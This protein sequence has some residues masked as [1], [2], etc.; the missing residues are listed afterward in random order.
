MHHASGIGVAKFNPP[1][2][3]K[4]LGHGRSLK[5]M[6][7]R[8]CGLVARVRHE[9]HKS[10][11][12]NSLRYSMLADCPATTFSAA[13]NAAMSVG[14]FR[15][16]LQILVVDVKRMWPV[17][18]DED[19]IFFGSLRF[20][21]SPPRLAI[22]S[23]FCHETFCSK[24][25]SWENQTEVLA[26]MNVKYPLCTIGQHAA[27]HPSVHLDLQRVCSLWVEKFSQGTF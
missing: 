12:F 16:Q 10:G 14:Q 1:W 24:K 4:R 15:K 23:K 22:L 8:P 20:G 5:G 18:I 26:S 11:T 19:R 13:Y 25:C 27:R 3:A 7:E 17:S 2:I 21:L 9:G 6:P